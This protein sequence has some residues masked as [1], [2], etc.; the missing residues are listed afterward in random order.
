[1][2]PRPNTALEAKI[3]RHVLAQLKAVPLAPDRP[4]IV[5]DCD[6]VMVALASHLGRFVAGLGIEMRLERYQ[7]EGA[8]RDPE[9]GRRLD[10]QEALGLIHRFFSE[11]TER[12]E[13]ID[14]A[15]AALSR[16][17]ERAQIVVLTNVP[18]HAREARIR[19]LDALGMG[20]PLVENSGGKGRALAWLAE[21]VGPTLPTAFIDD[22]P[23]QIESAAQRAPRVRR[24]QFTGAPGLAGLLPAAK[25]A[26]H[27]VASWAAL[28]ALLARHLG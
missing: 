1:M 25:E 22:S 7:L 12:Q 9:T 28:E 20:Y 27:R 17:A 16:L 2:A 4:L 18:R 26:D 24:V 6:E 14:G 3:D 23:G 5:V 11:E 21:R 19:N 10:F 8:F 15:A 13:A